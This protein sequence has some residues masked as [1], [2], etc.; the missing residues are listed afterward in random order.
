MSVIKNILLFIFLLCGLAAKEQVTLSPNYVNNPSFEEY[1]NCPSGSGQLYECKYWWGLSTDYFNACAAPISTGCSVPSNFAGYQSAL[2]G[3]AYADAVIYTNRFTVLPDRRE[4]IKAK[5]N[6]S[7]IANKR[8]CTNFYVSLSEISLQ[9]YNSYYV[10]LDSIGLLFTKDS[11]LDS[12]TAI[13][14]NGIKVQNSIF[15]IDTINWFK[16]SN[17]F[18]ASGGEQY[19]TIGNFDDYIYWPPGKK[20]Q[21][22]V[23]IDDISVC[24]CS[25]KF[26]LGNDT[27]LCVG[28]SLIL[29]PKMLNAT[30]TWQD[31]STDSIYTVTHAGTYW[32]KAFFSDYNITTYDTINIMYKDCDTTEK[33]IPDIY[34]PNSFTPNGDG[35][36]DVFKAVSLYEF[37]QFKLSVFSHWGDM[38]FDSYDINKG[39]DGTYKGKPVPMGVYVYQLTATIKDT[40][41][42]RK[43]TGR[44]TVV[45]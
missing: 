30:Y 9:S 15:N 1:Y 17:S 36:N 24:E 39:W 6:D 35:K 31:G 42:Q 10:L 7:L 32:V 40:G 26:N 3:E 38:V 41:E 8:Y 18:V 37:S 23:Y 34:I 13:S 22:D 29:K 12:I 20:G 4:T 11:V 14:S 19:L 2:S 25:F 44:V 43:I 27:T 16:I 5:L 45:R 21:T 28:Q 33:I